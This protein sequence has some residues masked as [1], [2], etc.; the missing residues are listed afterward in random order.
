M[1]IGIDLNPRGRV[2]MRGSGSGATLINGTS[3]NQV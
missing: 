1:H 3:L 2:T